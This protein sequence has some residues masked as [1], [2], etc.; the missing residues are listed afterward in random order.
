[1]YSDGDSNS[2]QPYDC[3]LTKVDLDNGLYGDYVFYKMQLLIDTNRELYVIL[4]RYGR[5]G[6]NGMH[7]R[8]PFNTIEE[9]KKEYNSIF[10]SKSGNDWTS[11]VYETFSKQNKKYNLVRVDYT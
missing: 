5:I 11:N 8:T 10:K 2:L 4:T 7:Q 6:E 9:A 3:Y 1:M